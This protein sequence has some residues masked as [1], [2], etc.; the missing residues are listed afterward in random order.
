M[1]LNLTIKNFILIDELSI[2]FFEGLTVMSGETGAGKS[3]ILYA[4]E[5][6]FGK[7]IEK[8]VIR[9]DCSTSVLSALYR[10]PTDKYSDLKDELNACGIDCNLE[11]A[12]GDSFYNTQTQQPTFE[13]L[14]RRVVSHDGRSRFFING[15]L[16]N[17]AQMKNIG[18]HIVEVCGQY[19]SHCLLNSRRHVELID[20]YACIDYTV[21]SMRNAFREWKILQDKY[22]QLTEQ[23]KH[24]DSERQF[25]R[26]T[27]DELLS[28]QP[29]PNE[30][31]ILS[32]KRIFLNEI[33][34]N[35]EILHSALMCAKTAESSLRTMQKI[36]SKG[37]D[38]IVQQQQKLDGIL[39][40]LL[41]LEGELS[42][43]LTVD[44]NHANE[45]DAV[46]QRLSALKTVARKNGVTVDMLHTTLTQAQAKL[47]ELD[48]L[49]AAIRECEVMCE[50]GK[51]KYILNA[52]I[53][54]HK[55][56][57]ACKQL[58]T[59]VS[60]ELH[61]L[62]MEYMIIDAKCRRLEE[63]D[64]E[65][66]GI[67]EVV[68][69]L[70]TNNKMGF[71]PISDVASGGEL[72]RLMLSFKAVLT[73]S[74][75]LPILVF[76]EI[77]VGLGGAVASM[78]GLKLRSLYENSTTITQIFAITHQPQIASFAN[79]H[80][81]IQKIYTK[82]GDTVTDAHYLCG[83]SERE[84]EI[85][86]MIS[87]ESATNEIRTAANSMLEHASSMVRAKIKA[88]CDSADHS[89]QDLHSKQ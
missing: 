82:D 73:K 24:C 49:D 32:S 36:I 89:S 16:S 74:K 23:A 58:C 28:L 60:K 6:I 18:E 86:R 64:W 66:N 14:L 76:D 45:L 88:H 71:A 84:K 47:M 15:T 57:E 29:Y 20:D 37:G 51:K 30:E 33:Q 70:H 62:A 72:S 27:I 10:L 7:K 81:A 79:H 41:D 25:L 52:T 48:E 43:L 65:A 87:S 46:E 22:F 63:K 67:S 40:E 39:L 12:T 69:V 4:I 77:D 61:N 50:A 35:R 17:A 38:T 75:S 19:G 42:G 11:Q 21:Q 1:L 53:V 56:I 2:D 13:L 34:K 54:E 8:K 5:L 68:F 3:I 83:K 85:A 59:E 9:N 78:V 26:H 80:I 44:E 31:E 55:R